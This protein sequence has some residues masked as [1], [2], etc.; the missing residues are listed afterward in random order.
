MS[1]NYYYI[2]AKSDKEYS[3]IFVDI[4]CIKGNK[5][6]LV[7]HIKK[8]KDFC[9][10][11]DLYEYFL[12]NLDKNDKNVIYVK[13]DDSEDILGCCYMT[14][15]E[16]IEI[17]CICV[18]DKN[19]KGVGTLLLN[20][21]KDLAIILNKNIELASVESAKKFY[22]KYGFEEKKENYHTD[23]ILKIQK[24]GKINKSI[25]KYKSKRIRKTNKLYEL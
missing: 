23:M 2:C 12:Y 4:G 5:K 3:S 6:V 21:V 9:R 16:M 1:Y 13:K 8:N 19:I 17:V 15:S 22:I 25:R 7:T 18:P 14:I 20:K 24:G 10:G 11:E